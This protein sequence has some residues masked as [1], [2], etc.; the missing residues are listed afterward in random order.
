MEAELATNKITVRS[1]NECYG[2][3][4]FLFSWLSNLVRLIVDMHAMQCMGLLEFGI[5][6]I[7][8]Y[9]RYRSC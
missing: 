9:I 6:Q 7:G 3:D 4:L 5:M 2:C 1:I 8:L